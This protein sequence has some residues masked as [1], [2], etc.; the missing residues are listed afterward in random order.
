MSA[1]DSQCDSTGLL[2]KPYITWQLGVHMPACCCRDSR[3]GT[4]SRH[5][6]LG[7]LIVMHH[8]K[9]PVKVEASWACLGPELTVSPVLP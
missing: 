1:F 7:K 9:G 6:L 8:S 4:T 5:N 3:L 2:G